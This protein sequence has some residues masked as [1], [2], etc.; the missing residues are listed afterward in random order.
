MRK[1][2]LTVS[3]KA[4]ASFFISVI[5]LFIFSLTS[6]AENIDDMSSEELDE[7]R[8]ALYLKT[9]ATTS[10]PWY[11]FAAVDSYERGLR[12]ARNDLPKE[13]GLIAIHISPEKWQGE[14]NPHQED[15]NPQSI[16]FFGGIGKDG[17]NDGMADLQDDEDVL[18]SF[19]SNLASYGFR[20]EDI[21]VGLWDY[22]QRD[23][24]V[25]L[26]SGHAK[27][28][29]T[30]N[31]LDL[32]ERSFPVPLN[33]NY[34]YRSTWGVGRGWGG[35]RIHEGTD[36]FAGHGL[37]VKATTFGIVELKGWNKFGGW[38]VGIRDTN[39][40]YHYYAHLS[41]F[42][43]GLE[44]GTVVK[45]GDIIGYVGSSGYGK[46]GTQGKFPPHLHY[47]MYRDNGFIEWSF[48]PHPS[49]N[50]WERA[51]RKRNKSG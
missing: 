19:A 23:K 33:A 34:S 26:I 16:A 51:E 21:Q 31:S 36:I 27:T 13:E 45:P 46:E 10:I 2:R 22:Y 8:M 18:F 43:K 35:K 3:K 9:E 29:Q 11:Y 50:I 14:T 40:V 30:F 44:R 37:Q 28:Y 12:I 42:E 24:A 38:R 4:I 20:N 17:N 15:Q 5:F 32:R 25:E 41:S 7:K 6:M 39:N 48:D 47:G 49:L 1:E